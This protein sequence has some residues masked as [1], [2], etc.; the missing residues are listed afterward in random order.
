MSIFDRFF[1][2]WLPMAIVVNVAILAIAWIGGGEI[3]WA[4]SLTLTLSL[5]FW[6]ASFW[7]GYVPVAHRGVLIRFGGRVRCSSGYLELNE[8]FNFLFP[9]LE[10]VQNFSHE[11][12]RD[13]NIEGESIFT[14]ETIE[15]IPIFG[16]IWRI[17]DF[18]KAIEVNDGIVGIRESLIEGAKAIIREVFV[19]CGIS[20]ALRKRKKITADLM[21][22]MGRKLN[23]TT[24]Q[25]KD[26]S[27]QEDYPIVEIVKMILDDYLND[28]EK[29]GDLGVKVENVIIVDVNFTEASIDVFKAME[30]VEKARHQKQK[31]VVDAEA[32]LRKTT[33]EAEGEK[34]KGEAEAWK[35]HCL[36]CRNVG[37]DPNTEKPTK[38]EAEAYKDYIVS[39][40]SVEAL[41]R[42]GLT[43]V[44]DNQEVMKI[45]A[46][47]RA[48]LLA[49]GQSS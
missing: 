1:W 26:F 14:T 41:G 22:Q 13:L 49:T 34:K 17:I 3:K 4:F 35:L 18:G 48:G 6:I 36:I 23:S 2:I 38:E 5:L 42:S 27:N 30:A 33:K 29:L 8:G 25:L 32:D 46:S 24:L 31:V 10:R 37:K 16:L 11:V 39:L 28:P 9:G 45:I 15:I 7:S 44:G 43:I 20:E 21:M 19:E 47:L 12:Q 40:S